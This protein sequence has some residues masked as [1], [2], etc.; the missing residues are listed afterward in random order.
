MAR[1]LLAEKL[2]AIDQ[3]QAQV[4]VTGNPG[5]AMQLAA[6][7]QAAERSVLVLHLVELLD[8]AQTN[9][10]DRVA[11]TATLTAEH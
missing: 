10:G 1:K 11:P 7:L 9:R 2:Q 5:C 6:G 8:L 3:T 4:V